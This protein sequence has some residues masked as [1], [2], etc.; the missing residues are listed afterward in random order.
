MNQNYKMNDT[1]TIHSTESVNVFYFS[2][3]SHSDIEK[4]QVNVKKTVNENGKRD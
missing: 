1:I 3:L 4:N 2:S